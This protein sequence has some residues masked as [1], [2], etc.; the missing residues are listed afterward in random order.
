M[1]VAA[2]LFLWVRGGIGQYC[3]KLHHANDKRCIFCQGTQRVGTKETTEHETAPAA[4]GNQ[5]TNRDSLAC[6]GVE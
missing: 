5:P 4:P 1:L 3:A 2:E 6:S